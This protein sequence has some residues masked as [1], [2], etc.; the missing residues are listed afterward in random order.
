MSRGVNE[1]S[2]NERS[3]LLADIREYLGRG[4]SLYVA[5]LREGVPI[6]LAREILPVINAREAKLGDFPLSIQI[7]GIATILLNP[8]E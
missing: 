1:A 4:Q 5:L 2:I 3:L 7:P 8:N 6:N